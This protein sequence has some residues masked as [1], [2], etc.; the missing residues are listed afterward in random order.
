[1]VNSVNFFQEKT[2]STSK[3]KDL[4]RTT[5]TITGIIDVG[6]Q[7]PYDPTKPSQPTWA[8]MFTTLNGEVLA[9]R[10]TKS[11]HSM[12]NIVALG[13]AVDV[14]LELDSVETLMGKQVAIT[15]ENSNTSFPK[16]VEVGRLESF[17]EPMKTI[18]AEHCQFVEDAA[19]RMRESDG[20]KWVMSLPAEV[21]RL[22]GSRVVLR[23]RGHDDQC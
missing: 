11:T 2:M 22:I 12:S 17:D 10:Y 9:K 7:R 19:Q 5:A 23:S 21:R 1:M 18:P 13:Q 20:K 8:L 14:D 6:Q 16:V 3:H 4:E 15:V